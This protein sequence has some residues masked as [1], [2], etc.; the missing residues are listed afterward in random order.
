MRN[1]SGVLGFVAAAVVLLAGCTQAV[2]GRGSGAAPS[3]P[4][5]STPSFR[6]VV[7]TAPS[8]K[9]APSKRAS[10]TAAT[11]GL[12][13]RLEPLPRGAEDWG[14]AWSANVTPTPKQF[15]KHFYNDSYRTAALARL[16]S[17]GLTGIAHRTWS[18]PDDNQIDLILLDFNTASGAALRYADVTGAAR[19]DPTLSTFLLASHPDDAQGFRAKKVGA[20]GFVDSRAYA[21]AIGS[22]VVIEAFYFSDG[23][24][25]LVDL[26]TWLDRQITL[27]G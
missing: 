8:S 4:L 20:D 21:H 10:G 17:Q 25:Q 11:S 1:T 9:A 24:L 3:S 14:D 13:A 26:T 19:A 12:V 16:T 2:T 6:T 18:A 5:S 22:R 27:A 15:V 7:P 23:T